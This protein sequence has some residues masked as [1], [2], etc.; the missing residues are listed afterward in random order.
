MNQ[1]Q[2]ST[3]A[4]T[5]L[6]SLVSPGTGRVGGKRGICNNCICIVYNHIHRITHVGRRTEK[7]LVNEF[8]ARSGGRRDASEGSV[9]E[10]ELH[11]KT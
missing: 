5:R 11:Y 7:V 9:L 10:L 3:V 8:G 6:T 1:R 4:N 2:L